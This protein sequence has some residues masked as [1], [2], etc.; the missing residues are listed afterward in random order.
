VSP[1][2]SR[3]ILQNPPNQSLSPPHFPVPAFLL[4]KSPPRLLTPPSPHRT[5]AISFFPGPSQSQ[6][7]PLPVR[8][9]TGPPHP[10]EPAK[11]TP[12]PRFPA[13]FL[14]WPSTRPLFPPD[15]PTPDPTAPP[16]STPPFLIGPSV[17]PLSPP[18]TPNSSPGF[19][20]IN[21]I[22]PFPRFLP[23]IAAG[24][25]LTPSFPT[26]SKPSPPAPSP[27]PS[28][29]SPQTPIFVAGATLFSAYFLHLSSVYFMFYS[30]IYITFAA[31]IS[32]PSGSSQNR[33][34]GSYKN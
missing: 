29:V 14:T 4:A 2:L 23:H 12:S 17:R 11:S 6:S 33:S 28:K 13:F 5:I 26:P 20:Q 7:R 10:P 8:L 32:D 24:H 22:S 21:P 3:S 31:L 9:L 34:T 15:P 16:I 1:S 30:R 19:S 25:P 18:R 27:P